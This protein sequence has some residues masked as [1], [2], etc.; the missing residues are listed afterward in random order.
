MKIN[1]FLLIFVFCVFTINNNNKVNA[2]E[3]QEEDL[4]SDEMILK[5][6]N[7]LD[8]LAE[9]IKKRQNFQ[10]GTKLIVTDTRE[11]IND[12]TNVYVKKFDLGMLKDELSL[13]LEDL[14]KIVN[15]IFKYIYLNNREKAN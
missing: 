8:V 7:F 10:E 14:N 2:F 9:N 5:I 3:S 11:N 13:F 12:N 15:K 4:D 1:A 6:K